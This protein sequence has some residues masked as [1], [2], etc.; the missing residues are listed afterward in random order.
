VLCTSRPFSF[1]PASRWC[2]A[3]HPVDKTA[4]RCLFAVGGL[5]RRQ[6]IAKLLNIKLLVLKNDLDFRMRLSKTPEVP[7]ESVFLWVG[8]PIAYRRHVEIL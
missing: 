8:T 2:Y 4:T 3:E 1:F 5:I 6:F 7:V